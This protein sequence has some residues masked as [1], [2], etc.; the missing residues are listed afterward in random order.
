MLRF[1]T[2]LKRKQTKDEELYLPC[3]HTTASVD[4][5][6]ILDQAMLKL[7]QCSVFQKPMLYFFYGRPSYK[8]R[9]RET[10]VKLYE[11]LPVCFV[12]NPK[13]IPIDRAAAFDTGAWELIKQH[14]TIEERQSKE[15]FIF[16]EAKSANKLIDFFFGDNARYV[17][18]RVTPREEIDLFPHFEAM[19]YLRIIMARN[20]QIDNR[21]KTIEIHLQENVVLKNQP[22]LALIL[23]DRFLSDDYYGPKVKEIISEQETVLITYNPMDLDVTNWH[24]H[25]NHA[26]FN[27]LKET[28]IL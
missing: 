7:K 23:P 24:G 6:D 21:A 26:F 18:G 12:F 14:I 28:G 19:A 16:E 13:Q 25:I 8:L 5:I 17:E 11:Y 3:I 9:A 27:F 10:E 4:F 1:E 20:H 2:F 22:L 15:D